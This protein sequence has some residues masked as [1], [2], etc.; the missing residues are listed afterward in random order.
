VRKKAALLGGAI[1]GAVG[2]VVLR[3]RRGQTVE[4]EADPRADELRR[5]LAEA[6]E[7]AEHEDEFE[8][9]GM[10]AETIVEPDVDEARRRVHE[11]GRAKAEEM[12]ESGEGDEPA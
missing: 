11:A 2:A 5:K 3:R 1:A 10:G 12:R 4:P 8:A 6:R 7:A 9:A